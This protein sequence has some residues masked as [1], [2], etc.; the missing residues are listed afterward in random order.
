MA[1]R[2]FRVRFPAR[3]PMADPRR[4]SPRP[5]RRNT[6]ISR[7]LGRA[8]AGSTVASA[9]RCSD[10]ILLATRQLPRRDAARPAAPSR[11]AARHHRRAREFS[12]RAGASGRRCGGATPPAPGQSRRGCA[13]RAR[14]SRPAARA[15]ARGHGTACARQRWP[16]PADN[17]PPGS[18]DG[19]CD[20]GFAVCATVRRRDTWSLPARGPARQGAR[21][22][23]LTPVRLAAA[24]SGRRACARDPRTPCSPSAC[25][26][27]SWC[28]SRARGP[29]ASCCR[30]W[31]R[32]RAG[33]GASR[34]QRGSA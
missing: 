6:R 27:A 32:A 15:P 2:G 30:C 25:C 8:G 34:C 31:R 10:A 18:L 11:R 3:A 29:S 28:R 12:V 23:Y 14:T 9:V 5:E 21:A 4:K 16:P 19:R 24:R 1:R 20:G 26:R 33:C 13:G 17:R 7:R 22:A